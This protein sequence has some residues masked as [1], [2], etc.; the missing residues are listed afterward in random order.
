LQ[1]H[2]SALLRFF[3]LFSLV[4]PSVSCLFCSLSSYFPL[5]F[6]LFFGFL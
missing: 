2:C 5:F 6:L 4:F 1:S 3:N